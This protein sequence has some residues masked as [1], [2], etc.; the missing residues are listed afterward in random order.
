VYLTL[1][2]FAVVAI[3]DILPESKHALSWRLFLASVG[4]GYGALWLIGKYVAPIC[5]ACAMRHFEADHHHVHGRGLVFLV[6][7][8]GIHCF[9]DGLG[10]SAA[11]TIKAAFGLR[12]FGAIVIHK[13]PEGF[14]LGLMLMTGSR[15]EWH[16]F[17]MA[18][19]IETVTLGGAVLGAFWTHPSEFWL[20]LVLAHIGGTFLYLSVSGLKDAPVRVAQA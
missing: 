13:L 19:A 16:A 9:L 7:V 1:L 11:S 20:A 15:S 2:F 8:L 3:F 12:V 18:V 5:P 10:V 14:A 4:L 6:I 17:A